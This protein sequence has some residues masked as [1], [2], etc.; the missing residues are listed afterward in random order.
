VTGPQ[1][2]LAVADPSAAL[3]A[4]ADGLH[5]AGSGVCVTLIVGA[6]RSTVQVTVVEVVAELPHASVAVHVLVVEYKHPCFFTGPSDGVGVTGP[7]LSL[8][9]ADPSAALMAAADGLHPAGSGVCS[10]S[11]SGG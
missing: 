3:M 11:S 5:P 8:A 7:Q 2:S 4:A 1:L 9:V 10:T 6:I